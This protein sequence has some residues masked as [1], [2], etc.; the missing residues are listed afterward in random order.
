MASDD[1]VPVV[2]LIGADAPDPDPRGAGR[3]SSTRTL[4]ALVVGGFVL[5]TGLSVLADGGDE[6]APEEEQAPTTEQERSATSVP[7]PTTTTS[8]PLATAQGRAE[9]EGFA[10]ITVDLEGMSLVDL[11]S[12]AEVLTDGPSVSASA[13][14]RVGDQLLAR[15]VTDTF[16]VI[17]LD[18]EGQW[19]PLGIESGGIEVWTDGSLLVVDSSRILGAGGDGRLQTWELPETAR[20]FDA[21]GS[22]GDALVVNG[23]GRIYAI[24]TDGTARAIADGEAIGVSNGHIVA[25]S[26]DDELRCNPRLIDAT[27]SVVRMFPPLPDR[28]VSQIV[29]V[30]PSGDTA[31]IGGWAMLS[32]EESQALLVHTPDSG[33]WDIVRTASAWDVGRAAWTADGR[34]AWWGAD[35]DTVEV[36]RPDG[37]IVAVELGESSR[38]SAQSV[39][40]PL[41]D[42]RPDW[43]TALGR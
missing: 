11:G 22:V 15:S 24:A 26:C 13:L 6:G 25:I 32:V 3:R 34:A 20:A 43:L 39:L 42:L 37:T 36:L 35:G 2:E 29:S 30:S 27:G 28:V 18:G 41:E 12:G 31:I 16:D 38:Q 14:I 1:D 4:V 7:E 19:E 9:L 8:A 17:D 5:V 10:Q 33:D 21:V 23:F 40:L